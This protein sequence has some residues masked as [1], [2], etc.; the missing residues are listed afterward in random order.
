MA[1]VNKSKIIVDAVRTAAAKTV[2]QTSFDMEAGRAADTLKDVRRTDE[3]Y[4]RLQKEVLYGKVARRANFVL[5]QLDMTLDRQTD[6]LSGAA[7]VKPPSISRLSRLADI[8]PLRLRKKIKALAGDYQAEIDSL[9]LQGRFRMAKWN[10]CL[11]YLN[12]IALVLRSPVDA[13]IEM[14]RGKSKAE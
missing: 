7:P 1:R 14:W 6:E 10:K 11:A 12:C 8:T 3:I 9:S 4:V 2:K 5:W 13:G